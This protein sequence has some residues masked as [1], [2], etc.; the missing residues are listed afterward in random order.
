MIEEK[1]KTV[2]RP[3]T[4]A[5]IKRARALELIHEIQKL[6]IEKAIFDFERSLGQY[7]NSF[8]KCLTVAVDQIRGS[9]YPYDAKAHLAKARVVLKDIM[10]MLKE[11]KALE[12]K[13]IKLTKVERKFLK[14]ERET[15]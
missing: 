15:T 2:V 1:Q 14:K 7:L 11:T 13:L 5:E 6:K 12:E 3:R 8:N 9:L 10:E 4:K